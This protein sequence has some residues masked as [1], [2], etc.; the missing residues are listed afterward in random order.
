MNEEGQIYER[1]WGT[2][3]TIEQSGNYQVKH[4][5]VYPGKRLSL[6]Y[7]EHRNEHWTI[8]K[9]KGVAQLN[10]KSIKMDVGS[11]IVIPKL[12]KHRMTNETEENLEF[13]EIQVGEYLGEDDIVRIEDDFG[14]I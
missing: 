3:R 6:Q 1:P 14:R 9:G 8:V 7:H 11:F 4:I 2:Y 12:S 13:I 5:V 10:D